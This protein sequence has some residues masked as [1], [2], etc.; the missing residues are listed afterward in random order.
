M[1]RYFK[2]IRGYKPDDYIEIDETELKKAYYCFLLK[3]DSVYSGGAVQGREIK[4]IQPDYQRSMGWN[5]GYAPSP[6]DW[7]E[8]RQLGVD[9]EC[10]NLI[11]AAKE[12]AQFALTPGQREEAGDESQDQRFVSMREEF[13]GKTKMLSPQQKAEAQE[14]AARQDRHDKL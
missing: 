12:E 11:E 4:A 7:G 10:R 3:K 13:L 5:R 2:I 14:E 8:I 6:E 1:T 9:R